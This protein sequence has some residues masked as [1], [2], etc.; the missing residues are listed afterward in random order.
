[1]G[2]LLPSFKRSIDCEKSSNQAIELLKNQV[3]SGMSIGNKKSSLAGTVNVNK[4]RFSIRENSGAN[5]FYHP[6]VYGETTDTEKGCS[7][8]LDFRVRKECYLFQIMV[9]AVFIVALL[10]I[11]VSS[12][13]D[14]AHPDYG[15]LAILSLAF[16]LSQ[17]ILRTRFNASAERTVKELERILNGRKK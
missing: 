8:S 10:I 16:L 4:K 3:D 2:F 11:A 7:V 5:R 17:G 12:I 6:T 13:V 1:M 9:Y 14:K 15:F